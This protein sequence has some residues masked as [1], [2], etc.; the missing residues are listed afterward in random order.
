MRWV[1]L[2]TTM[3]RVPVNPDQ[4]AYL[5]SAPTGRG[6][7]VVFGAAAAGLHEIEAHGS[8]AEVAKALESEPADDVSPPSVYDA[9]A[10]ERMAQAIAPGGDGASLLTE[11]FRQ[12]LAAGAALT[13]ANGP[14]KRT[15]LKRGKA[16]R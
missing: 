3:G 11:E 2:E 1:W 9:D 6:A 12:A 16:R 8:L 15:A 14:P 10:Y 4:V 13:T 7:R 5:R